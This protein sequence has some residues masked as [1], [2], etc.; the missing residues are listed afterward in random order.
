MEFEYKRRVVVAEW[1]ASSTPPKS[2]ILGPI[3]EDGPE[4]SCDGRSSVLDMTWIKLP[5]IWWTWLFFG[6]IKSIYKQTD[7]IYVLR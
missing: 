6:V 2:E 5:H 7:Y 1:L 3:P 4:A